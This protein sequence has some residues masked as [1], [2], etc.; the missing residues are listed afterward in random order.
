MITRRKDFGNIKVYPAFYKVGFLKM[1]EERKRKE[2]ISKSD[3]T[4]IYETYKCN[5]QKTQ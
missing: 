3:G 2:I 1:E 4:E 5:H